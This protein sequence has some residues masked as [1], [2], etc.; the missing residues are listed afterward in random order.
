MTLA[1]HL[2]QLN[3]KTQAWVDEDPDNRW[4]G[5]YAEELSYWAEMGIETV[6][7]FQR[8]EMESTIWELYKD[9]TGVRPRH[10]DF[11]AM[12][13]EELTSQYDYLLREMKAQ[14]AREAE[15]VAHCQALDKEQEEIEACRAAELPE[16]IDYVAC[17]YQEGWL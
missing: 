5:M 9:V 17:K 11:K 10:M 7:Q 13:D 3:A 6:A 12:S 4:A 8:W 2:K 14:E 16:T 1:E 15:Y